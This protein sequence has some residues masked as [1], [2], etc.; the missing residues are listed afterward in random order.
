MSEA[1]GI[2]TA[3]EVGTQE[4]D[5]ADFAKMTRNSTGVDSVRSLAQ[6]AWLL[7]RNLGAVTDSDTTNVLR[8]F[9]LKFIQEQE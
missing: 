9:G 8:A 4:K 7:A 5:F 6:L 3:Y 1:L 2:V